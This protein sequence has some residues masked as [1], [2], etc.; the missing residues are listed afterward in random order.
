[1]LTTRGALIVLEGCDKA[2]KST[3][4]KLLMDALK[5][6]NIPAK[7]RTFPGKYIFF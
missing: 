5:Q 4:T 3:Q 2:G 1:M 7:Q 6:Y